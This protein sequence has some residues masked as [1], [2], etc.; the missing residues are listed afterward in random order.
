[1]TFGAQTA[2][3]AA[4][5]MIDCC[6][7]NG[8]NFLDTAN[9]YNKGAAEE[10]LGKLLAGRRHRIVLATK[11]RGA[12]GPGPDEKGLSSAAILR[13]VDESLKRL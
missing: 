11:V 1:M 10:M 8:I 5:R 3:A 9:V 6:F 4:A 2:E 7:A 12:M 13:A